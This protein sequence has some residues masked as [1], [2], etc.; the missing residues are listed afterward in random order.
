MELGASFP[1]KEIGTDPDA[2]RDYAQAVED[3]GFAH[4]LDY[5]HVMGADTTNRPDWDYAAFP[6]TI[7]DQFHEPLTLFAFL[8]GCTRRL[9]LEAS[10]I[11]LPQRQ[12]A[13]VAKQAAE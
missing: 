1:G 3:L 7:N 8:A 13:M 4:L 2:I 12:T 5:D 9:I 11:V 6:Y 10:V